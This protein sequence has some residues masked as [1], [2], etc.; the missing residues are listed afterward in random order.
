MGL[1]D[2]GGNVVLLR[3][4]GSDV[5]PYMQTLHFSFGLGAF[6]VTPPPSPPGRQRVVGWS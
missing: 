2:T 5:G 3:L 6:L 1:M 4:W